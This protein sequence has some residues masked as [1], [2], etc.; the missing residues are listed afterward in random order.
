MRKQ[1][2]KMKKEQEQERD[3]LVMNNGL[4]GHS[5][6]HHHEV[7]LPSAGGPQSGAGA[8][9]PSMGELMRRRRIDGPYNL[10][11]GD[12]AVGVDV[13]GVSSLGAASVSA[14]VP[15][16]GLSDALGMQTAI[17]SHA[18]SAFGLEMASTSSMNAMT[19]AH[20]A[21]AGGYGHHHYVQQH[22]Q[23]MY[24]R[25]AAG[26]GPTPVSPVTPISPVDTYA[27]SGNG[28]NGNNGDL[29]IQPAAM[30]SIGAYYDSM[31][32]LRHQSHPH[33]HQLQEQGQGQGQ[34]DY[35]D[36]TGRSSPAPRN[37]LPSDATLCSPFSTHPLSGSGTG[38]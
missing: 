31:G 19:G 15:T 29:A 5:H 27:G 13:A 7:N 8:A 10:H 33:H 4:N 20:G 34:M 37:Q 3:R 18:H 11:H 1:W 6:H 38:S 9:V 30:G 32:V 23:E 26:V 35:E 28:N 21:A 24:R 17:D 16:T 14:S 25:A 12:A 36:R 2:R 22:Q